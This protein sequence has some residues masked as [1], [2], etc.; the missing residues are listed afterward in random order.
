M[1]RLTA[2]IYQGM[3]GD[4]PDPDLGPSGPRGGKSDWHAM[5]AERRR[6]SRKNGEKSVTQKKTRPQ[7]DR[8]GVVVLSFPVA[9]S[10][11]FQASLLGLGLAE[12]WVSIQHR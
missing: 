7:G 11:S 12:R 5:S 1:P 8:V 10:D 6:F 9:E 2:G 4:I 3:I